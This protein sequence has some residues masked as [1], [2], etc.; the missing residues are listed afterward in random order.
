[1]KHVLHSDLNEVENAEKIYDRF[2]NSRS[3][4]LLFF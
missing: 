4:S 2:I 3:A 1:M